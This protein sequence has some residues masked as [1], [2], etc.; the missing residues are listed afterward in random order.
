MGGVGMTWLKGAQNYK[1][2]ADAID[3]PAMDNDYDQVAAQFQ[4]AQTKSRI[5]FGAGGALLGTGITLAIGP[6]PKKA[7]KAKQYKSDLNALLPIPL[8]A[9]ASETSLMPQ[10]QRSLPPPEPTPEPQ[11]DENNG[12]GIWD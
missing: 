2:E 11:S 8:S 12:G 6:T 9:Y 7:K 4:D 5:F 1:Q 10:R 3:D